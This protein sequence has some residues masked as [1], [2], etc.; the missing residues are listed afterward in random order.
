MAM[1][2][3]EKELLEQALRRFQGNV[4][5]AAEWLE[6]TPRAVYQ[7]INACGL[8]LNRYRRSGE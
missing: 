2:N 8:D 6:L 3:A 5:K 4:A 1:A 7:K